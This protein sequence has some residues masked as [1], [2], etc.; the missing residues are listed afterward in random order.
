MKFWR[1]IV[2]TC[3]LTLFGQLIMNAKSFFFIV[4]SQTMERSVNHKI[5]MWL[6]SIN[7]YSVEGGGLVNIGGRVNISEGGQLTPFKIVLK[8]FKAKACLCTNWH[9][10][11]IY[12]LIY[13]FSFMHFP[14]F[15]ILILC[16]IVYNLFNAM[17]KDLWKVEDFQFLLWIC[18]CY[19]FVMN[20]CALLFC[21]LILLL[22]LWQLK[23]ILQCSFYPHYYSHIEEL[24]GGLWT[25]NS[26]V[27]SLTLQID[28][29]HRRYLKPSFSCWSR[30]DY[31]VMNGNIANYMAY[32]NRKYKCTYFVAC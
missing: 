4:I 2:G 26:K 8:S 29:R 13:T 25:P 5:L 6:V 1:N 21:V 27:A 32:L 23:V 18:L 14:V 12:I 20:L 17:L 30:G 28:W 22:K 3:F 31:L 24:R 15:S 11:F 7:Y 9:H 10:L 16:Y 19:D